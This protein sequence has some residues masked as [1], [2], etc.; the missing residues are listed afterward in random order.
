MSTPIPQPPPGGDQDR[1]PAINA[2]IWTFTSLALFC[3][4]LRLY[5]RLILT[6]NF[7]WDDFWIIISMCTPTA[8]L[9]NPVKYKPKCWDLNSVINYFIFA[10][11]G[12][13][14]CTTLPEL[15]DGEDYTYATEGIEIMSSVEATVI[16]IAACLPTLRPVFLHFTGRKG[17]TEHPSSNKPTNRSSNYQLHSYG[18]DVKRPRS[19]RFLAGSK[20][21]RKKGGDPYEIN[22]QITNTDLENQGEADSMEDRILP[23]PTY[24]RQSGGAAGMGG[25]TRT[26]DVEVN[27]D[28]R[29]SQQGNNGFGHSTP[30]AGAAGERGVTSQEWDRGAKGVYSPRPYDGRAI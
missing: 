13:Y 6:T 7:G 5:G 30:S 22:T 2:A 18:S 24:H 20:G 17:T 26:F 25:I 3:V 8:G 21:S 1:G 11:F 16:I 4:L 27:R 9:W 29:V 19:N 12:I 14:K 15:H 23:P 10:G 28:G